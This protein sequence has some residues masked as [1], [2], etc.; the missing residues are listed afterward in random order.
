MRKVLVL[1]VSILM[2]LSVSGM[3]NADSY[4]FEDMIDTWFGSYDSVYIDQDYDVSNVLYHV[5]DGT[6]NVASP[7]SYTH[8][9]NDDVNFLAGDLVTEAWLELD[10]TDMDLFEAGDSY[11]STFFGLIKWD[12]RE[13]VQ[14]TYDAESSSWIEISSDNDVQNVMLDIDWLND[15]GL[16]HAYPN[17]AHRAIQPRRS[18][19]CFHAPVYS[20]A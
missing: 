12:G 17:V 9:I 16:L 2:V 19:G 13:N 18:P 20:P 1:I 6:P 3:A 5:I 4:A 8:D 11:G 7:F 15:D 10:F 14:Y